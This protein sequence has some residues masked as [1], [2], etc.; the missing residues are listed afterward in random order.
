MKTRNLTAGDL[1]KVG[2]MIKGVLPDL[3]RMSAAKP[4]ENDDERKA[5]VGREF[6]GLLLDKCYDDA[7]A[8][9]ADVACMSV[10]EFNLLP[11]SAPLDVIDAIQK[12]ES[13][14]DF[15]T[16]LASLTSSTLST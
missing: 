13:A 12:D 15:F 11:L 3:Q 2:K 16:R 14:A 10:E 5:R 7:W 1:F 4:G 9:L 6:I 8:W